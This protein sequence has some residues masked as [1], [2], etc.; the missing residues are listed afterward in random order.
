MSVDPAP[1]PGVLG[2][3]VAMSPDVPYECGNFLWFRQRFLEDF[4]Y[5]DR[6]AVAPDRQRQGIGRH[7]YRNVERFARE[8]DFARL[9]CEVN[10]RP[11]NEQSLRFHESEGFQGIEE[12]D[13]DY[14]P[15]VLMMQK[16]LT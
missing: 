13:T 16:P 7:L 6:V 14:G 1:A 15:R 2:F 11:R 10:V 3:L 8:R 4:L 12:R 9:T 5:I